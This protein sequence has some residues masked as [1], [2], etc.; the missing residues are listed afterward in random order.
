MSIKKYDAKNAHTRHS[1][2]AKYVTLIN[3]IIKQI[4]FK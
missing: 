4:M 1:D 2:P 3:I